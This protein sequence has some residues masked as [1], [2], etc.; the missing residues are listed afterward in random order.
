MTPRP[1]YLRTRITFTFGVTVFVLVLVLSLISGWVVWVTVDEEIDGIARQGLEELQT[2]CTDRTCS[3]GEMMAIA[4]EAPARTGEPHG[5]ARVE[6]VRRQSLG[7][8]WE[9]GAP[10]AHPG[11]AQRDQR[12][13]EAGAADALIA[14]AHARASAGILPGRPAPG[15]RARELRAAGRGLRDRF[16]RSGD[17]GGAP[18]GRRLRSVDRVA[19]S[20]RTEEPSGAAGERRARGDPRR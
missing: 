15:T 3:Q 6:Q 20:A 16:H 4:R 14:G 17:A 13:R 9:P 11:A 18:V 8:A 12:A 2:F 1:W 10:A 5:L 19:R 7:G